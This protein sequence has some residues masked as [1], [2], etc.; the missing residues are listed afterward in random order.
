MDKE[1]EF[2]ASLSLIDSL[3]SEVSFEDSRILCRS[4]RTALDTWRLCCTNGINTLWENEYDFE[5]VVKHV[6]SICKHWVLIS[7]KRSLGLGEESFQAY[8]DRFRNA[9]QNDRIILENSHGGMNE[10][11]LSAWCVF[12]E[13][14]QKEI[15]YTYKLTKYTGDEFVEKNSR[16]MFEMLIVIKRSLQSIEGRS[17]NYILRHRIQEIGRKNAQRGDT[18]IIWTNL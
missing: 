3:F 4:R 11:A 7:Q 14:D 16:L 6:C 15:T 8:F 2:R 18:S 10:L 5:A 9:F 17:T 1:E 13:S 12:S